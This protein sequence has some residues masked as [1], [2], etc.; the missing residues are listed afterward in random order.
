MT[1]EIVNLTQQIASEELNHLEEFADQLSRSLIHDI[2]QS[3]DVRTRLIAYVMTREENMYTTVEEGDADHLNST[4]F[5]AITEHRAK[6]R[7]RLQEGI[8]Q[9]Q[10]DSDG[11]LE[12]HGL[13]NPPSG[14]R[15]EDDRRKSERRHGK[16]NRDRKGKDDQG[17]ISHWFG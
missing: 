5:P 1:E 17:N 7:D 14:E 11:D 3:W 10:Q 13:L 15:R 6:I 9:L 2:L 8:T 12:N 16:L 4:N